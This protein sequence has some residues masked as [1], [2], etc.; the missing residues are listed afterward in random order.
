MSWVV[1]FRR[2]LRQFEM[3]EYEALL[4]VLANVFICRD[5][6]YCRIW[7]VNPLVCSLVGLS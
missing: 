2:S 3:V 7:K 6:E 4:S 1:P 5:Q